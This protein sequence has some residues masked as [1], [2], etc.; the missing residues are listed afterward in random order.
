MVVIKQE[1]YADRNFV[2]IIEKSTVKIIIVENY[3]RVKY[4]EK[5]PLFY[6]YLFLQRFETIRNG[7]TVSSVVVKELDHLLT[8]F[9]PHIFDRFQQALKFKVQLL[10][11]IPRKIYQ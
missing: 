6:R 5:L 10:E 4:V 9:Q 11:I 7:R 2:E 1:F 3:D 8:T